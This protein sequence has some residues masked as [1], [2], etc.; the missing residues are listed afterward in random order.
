MTGIATGASGGHEGGQAF[1]VALREVGHRV[2]D[3]LAPSWAAMIFLC[4]I[5]RELATREQIYLE[6]QSGEKIDVPNEIQES[7]EGYRVYGACSD[8]IKTRKFWRTH[9]IY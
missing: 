5:I 7:V 9:S 4:M 6:Q 2:H 1:G 3:G 8:L